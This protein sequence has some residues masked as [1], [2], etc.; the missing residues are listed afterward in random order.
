[1]KCWQGKCN[2]KWERVALKSRIRKCGWVSPNGGVCQNDYNITYW[3]LLGPQIWLWISLKISLV[4]IIWNVSWH[5]HLWQKGHIIQSLPHYL[6]IFAIYQ[7]RRSLVSE[8]LPHMW[9]E[10]DCLH[11]LFG[12]GFRRHHHH[13][14]HHHH[15]C[16]QHHGEHYQQHYRDQNSDQNQI[17]SYVGAR[18]T[19]ISNIINT[20][21]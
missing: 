5:N 1:M 2:W 16:H 7:A 18:G 13:H 9:Q 19:G 12:D 10:E 6:I 21:S 11:C 14:H 15:N 17:W 3:G 8:R 20:I 4:V